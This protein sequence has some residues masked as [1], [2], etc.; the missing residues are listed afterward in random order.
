[1]PALAGPAAQPF[2]Q[3]ALNGLPFLVWVEDAQGRLLMAN[4]AFERWLRDEAPQPGDGTPPLAFLDG[5]RSLGD[6]GGGAADGAGAQTP[7]ERS[8]LDRRGERR[9][10]EVSSA[11]VRWPTPRESA[12][13]VSRPHG[14][15]AHGSQAHEPGP[16]VPELQDARIFHARDISSRKTVD[17]SLKRTLAFVQGIIDAFPDFLFEGSA[18]GRYLNAWT[19]N[20][21]L[22][23]ASR[24]HMLGRTLDEVLSPESAAIAKAAFR[25]ADEAGLSFG[26]VI[27]IDTAV[28]RRSFELSVSKMPMG[29]GE[30][31]HFITVSRDVTARLDL[32]AELEQKARQFRSLVE[33]SP[34]AIAR[35]DPALRCLYAN[36]ALVARTALPSLVGLDPCAVFGAAAGQALK[37]RLAV[38]MADGDA[39]DFEMNWTDAQGQA[40]TT[41]V[42]LAPEF[43]ARRQIA[44][45]LLIGRDLTEHKRA[46]AE[47]RA[48][49]AAEAAS[50]AKG[51]F[52][53]SMSHEIRTPMNAI[54]GMSYLALQGNLDHQ[55]RRYVQ[56]VHRSAESLLGII[57]DILDFSK[58]EA[59]K[60]DMESID[61]DLADVMDGLAGLLGMRAEE[62]GLELIFDQSPLVPTRLVGDPSRLGQVLLN[63][64]NNAV[65][66]TEHGEIV[67]GVQVVER[68]ERH[69]TLRFEVRDTGIGISPA[70][71][72]RLFKP[73]VQ[74]D[75]ST[76]RRFGGTGLGLAICQRLVDLMG[77]TIE[78]DSEPGRGSRFSF[79]ARLGVQAARPAAAPDGL[80]DA[81]IL[82]VDDNPSARQI[83]V[84][85]ARGLGM[86]AESARDG[87][88]ALQMLAQEDARN[89][90]YHLAV[91]DWKMPRMD[92]LA[93]LRAIQEAR[94]RQPAPAVLMVTGFGADE[95]KQ[96]LAADQ[97]TFGAVLSKPVAPSSLLDA[98]AAA[99]GRTTLGR[100]GMVQRD[101]A[102]QANQARLRGARVLLVEDNAVNQELARALL[103]RAGI[104]VTVVEDGQQAVDILAHQSFDGVLMDCQM[105][106]MD[107]YEATALLR[108]QQK[109]RDLPIIAMTANAMV[110]D[111]EKA[112]A[113]G[114]NEQVG[115]PIKVDELFAT[116]ARWINPAAPA[117]D[118]GPA[119]DAELAQLQSL[120]GLE[121]S[122]WVNSRMGD[123]ALYR[124]LLGMFLQDQQRFPAPF[125]TALAAADLPTARRLAHNL[126]SLSATLGAHGVERAAAALEQACAAQ[127]PAARLQALLDELASH[128]LPVLDGLR[129]SPALRQAP[130][131][132]AGRTTGARCA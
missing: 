126:K 41:L 81:R 114:M 84:G 9:W 57:N 120:P 82:I 79:T 18:D 105:P 90:P 124:R 47:R 77:G 92:G 29:E 88:Q 19:K 123:T 53:A 100:P 24:E 25:E 38:L 109:L 33:N 127:E 129:Q 94:F 16:Q 3:S 89:D 96:R 10:M 69:A 8:Y 52:L 110:G 95:L 78:V 71:Q 4:E 118:A 91:I 45:A 44:S 26:K 85:M 49:E 14:S 42:H 21:E 108:R 83:L 93:C 37:Q 15:Q 66:F 58:I 61:F 73:F 70:D 60:L 36:P 39:L 87:A 132:A 101:E 99:L 56:T 1:M 20:P 35:F 128:L 65:K 97:L 48:R 98:C 104:V 72:Q 74:G 11:P 121:V 113:A 40:L 67:V 30:P 130:E 62:K 76:S 13:P 23:A 86:R 75:T 2:V 64:G 17:Q 106:V 46:E 50:R 55:Q 117:A 107:G 115:K 43:D 12:P 119:P 28:G 34:D 7:S 6:G 32:Q 63:L 51:E 102:L 22:L 27:A 122:T 103:G 68:D 112:L 125:E 111:R 131:P 116:L 59:G 54:I 5:H 31:P 80:Q